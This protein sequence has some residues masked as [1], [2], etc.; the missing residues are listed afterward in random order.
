M[1]EYL[2]RLSK[3][4]INLD[5]KKSLRSYNILLIVVLSALFIAGCGSNDKDV[6]GAD[7]EGNA[8]V[9][10]PD[11][12]DNNDIENG[13]E[14]EE[15]DA[16]LKATGDNGALEV[17]DGN[18]VG[19]Y[20]TS[21]ITKFMIIK[22]DPETNNNRPGGFLK[23][24]HPYIEEIGDSLEDV[25]MA[26]YEIDYKT[27]TDDRHEEYLIGELSEDSEFLN[28]SGELANEVITEVKEINTKGIDFQDGMEQARVKSEIIYHVTQSLD[29][30]AVFNR[31][32]KGA[33]YAVL[34]TSEVEKRDGEW[35]ITHILDGF[36][37]VIEDE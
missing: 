8:D 32:L 6:M 10:H 17:I 14:I 2:V 13:D 33:D 24:S 5:I 29:D 4:E 28:I 26:L 21:D 7:L 27:I 31:Y 1:F 15:N 25:L 36:P 18:P 16:G 9:T 37:E 22:K 23:D 20:L 3:G 19:D 11:L 35:K 34:P 12:N 30:G